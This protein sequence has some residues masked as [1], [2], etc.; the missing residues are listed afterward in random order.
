MLQSLETSGKPPLKKYM[1][2]SFLV[3]LSGIL[4]LI[5]NIKS[6]ISLIWV[7]IVNNMLNIIY[8]VQ[9]MQGTFWTWFLS[10]LSHAGAMLLPPN[11]LTSSVIGCE[12]APLGDWKD[13][14]IL[15]H[16]AWLKWKRSRQTLVILALRRLRQED[17][18]VEAPGGNGENKP[19][20]V[21]SRVQSSGSPNSELCEWNTF[22][23]CRRDINETLVAV[24]PFEGVDALIILSQ[25]PVLKDLPKI[26]EPHQYTAT[27]FANSP[28]NS[29]TREET[30]VL[31]HFPLVVI[32]FWFIV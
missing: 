12:A 15:E 23:S 3:P 22:K 25:T 19:P 14:G 31:K 11:G 1:R 21:G 7:L 18:E 16:V 29:G 5:I 4:I 24:F 2:D 10:L 20:T 17:S 32:C 9:K 26:Q 13:L 28:W 6:G 8:I 30:R 27:S